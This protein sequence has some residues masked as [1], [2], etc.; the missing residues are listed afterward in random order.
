MSQAYAESVAVA[1]S[2]FAAA[3]AFAE[4]TEQVLISHEMMVAPHSE[5]E[6]YVDR[7][8][9]EWARLA[10][11]AQYAL[12]AERERRVDVSGA[13]GVDR[14]AVRPAAEAVIELLGRADAEGRALLAVE[15]TQAEVVGAAL[16]ELDVARH[17]IDDVDAVE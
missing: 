8:G 16:L 5:S 12:R 17:D 11:E 1:H 14:V 7:R 6:T 10:L 4:E 2:P 13:D 9:R 15:G 3:R